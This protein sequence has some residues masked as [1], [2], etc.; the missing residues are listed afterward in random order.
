MAEAGQEVEITVQEPIT[1]PKNVSARGLRNI[2]NRTRELEP[3]RVLKRPHESQREVRRH[4]IS[5]ASIENARDLAFTDPLT[6]LH[7]RRWAEDDLDRRIA[8]SNR[9]KYLG[10]DDSLY[11]IYLDYDDFKLFNTAFGHSGGDAVLKLA[12]NIPTR[13]EEPISRYGGDEFVQAVQHEDLTPE[14]IALS[15]E[16]QKGIMLEI[17]RVLLEKA[18]V[19]SSETEPA[20]IPREVTLSF[21]IAKYEGETRD[22]LIKKTN[23]ALHYAK[24]HEK[25]SAFMALKGTDGNLTFSKLT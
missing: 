3:E 5:Q 15:I 17:S 23:L 10:K 22:E 18:Q 25:N 12:A 8:E 16:R 6:G 24:Q 7:N 19:I 11:L 4:A 2:I 20:N 13:P 9:L 21:G 14:E 1:S